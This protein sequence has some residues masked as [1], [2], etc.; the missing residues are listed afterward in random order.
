MIPKKFD[1]LKC[2]EEVIFISQTF[3]DC[4]PY[5]L[6]WIGVSMD[7]FE[8]FKRIIF[9]LCHPLPGGGYDMFSAWSNSKNKVPPTARWDDTF[10]WASG[11][12]PE[13]SPGSLRQA[14]PPHKQG[15]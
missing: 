14:T 2:R 4:S 3:T 5:Y 6:Q 10:G 1:C 12:A 7:Y 8:K 15:R 9:F 13:N 11:E